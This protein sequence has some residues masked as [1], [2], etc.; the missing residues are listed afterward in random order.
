ME[1]KL[2]QQS[3]EKRL[4][5]MQKIEDNK[6]L[7]EQMKAEF[8]DD[9][10]SNEIIKNFKKAFDN[11]VKGTRRLGLKNIID[12]TKKSRKAVAHGL[13][14]M[15]GSTPEIVQRVS[16]LI[17]EMMPVEPMMSAVVY[18]AQ[19]GQKGGANDPV[20]ILTS[21]NY[22]GISWRKGIAGVLRRLARLYTLLLTMPLLDDIECDEGNVDEDCQQ[23][24]FI[25]ADMREGKKLYKVCFSKQEQCK[26]KNLTADFLTNLDNMEEMNMDII[27][28]PVASPTLESLGERTAATAR[29]LASSTADPLIQHQLVKHVVVQGRHKA[30]MER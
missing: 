3:Q 17:N 30:K 28:K 13:A 19:G 11:K 25:L 20:N 16:Q 21:T 2:Y 10:A 22:F 23:S 29:L 26:I 12:R 1:Q 14:T 6:A 15:P 24:S 7:E 27:T 4:R 8:P 5:W 18:V 9:L